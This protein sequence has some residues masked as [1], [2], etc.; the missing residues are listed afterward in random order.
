DVPSPRELEVLAAV[1]DGHD[2]ATIARD[3]YISQATVKSHLASVFAKLG[4][5]TRTGAVAEARR[6]GHLR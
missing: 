1:A 2:N 4:V 6:R 5:A 3:L